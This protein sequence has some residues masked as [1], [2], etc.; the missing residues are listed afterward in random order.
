ML[1]EQIQVLVREVKEQ[2]CKDKWEEEDQVEVAEEELVEVEEDQV[3]ELEVALHQT[4]AVIK[5]VLQ[6]LLED[7]EV[8]LMVG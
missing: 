6:D 1:Q 8:A 7:P 2:E 3:E 4:L 5:E